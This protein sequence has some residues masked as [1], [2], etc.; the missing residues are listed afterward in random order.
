MGLNVVVPNATS[1]SVLHAYRHLYRGLL[2]AV[3]F[4]AP[5]RY[6]ARDQ[7]RDAF[8]KGDPETFDPAKITRTLE[9]LQGAA[10]EKG[11]EHRIL[12]SLLHTAF[13]RNNSPPNRY[14][15]STTVGK[16]LEATAYL[17]YEMTI[18]M[19]NDSMGLCLR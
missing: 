1:W 9:F 17:H 13:H 12:K 2:R 15:K 14:R 4:S 11:L 10:R 3:Q 16:H 5:N 18:A 6:T 7:L 19:L 8:R